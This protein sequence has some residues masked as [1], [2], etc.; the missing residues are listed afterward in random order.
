MKKEVA[1]TARPCNFWQHSIGQYIFYMEI[2]TPREIC[3]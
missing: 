3:P 2:G 1:A